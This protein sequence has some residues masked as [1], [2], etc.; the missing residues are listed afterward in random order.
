MNIAQV[1]I[2]S[3]LA[4]LSLASCG[5]TPKKES[6]SLELQSFQ[7]KEFEAPKAIVFGSVISVFQDIGYIVQSADKETGF[8]TAGSPAEDKTGFWEAMG[9]VSSS[10]Q[11]KATAFIEEIRSGFTTVRLN[12]VNT[13]MKSGWY[14]QERNIDEAIVDPETYRRAF[15]RI[16]DAIFIRSGSQ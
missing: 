6:T 8:I 2:F 1:V 4:P 7:A 15:A 16:D 14:G 12:F 10:G 13:R 9:G 3:I 11:T 5:G